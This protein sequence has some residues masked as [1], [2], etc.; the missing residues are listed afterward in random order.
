MTYPTPS[1][2]PE[3]TPH[4]VELDAEYQSDAPAQAP[5]RPEPSSYGHETPVASAEQDA[6]QP[7]EPRRGPSDGQLAPGG[8]AEDPVAALWGSDLVEHYRELWRQLQLRFVDDPRGATGDSGALVDDAVRALTTT[9]T[10]QKQA[11]DGW[12]GTT[13]DDTE[14]LRSALTRYRAFLDRLLG[15]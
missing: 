7:D 9:L 11:L 10:D 12:Q 15:L 14:V 13:G 2:Q 6:V 8:S 3:V 4:P 5:E 1:A